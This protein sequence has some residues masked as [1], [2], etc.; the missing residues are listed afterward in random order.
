MSK[1][2]K[3]FD[4]HQIFTEF[5]QKPGSLWVLLGVA[6]IGILLLLSGNNPREESVKTPVPADT[7]QVTEMDGIIQSEKRLESELE[8]T[9]KQ[10]AG[11]GDVSVDIHLKSGS[12]RIWER[13]VRV[14]KRSQ[15]QQDQLDTEESSSDEMVLANGRDGADNPVLREELAPEVNGVLIVASGAGDARVKQILT[16]TVMTIL[17]L[18]AHRVM[19]TA[20]VG[21]EN[22]S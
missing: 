18:P 6:G 19:V 2:T 20:G 7:A 11:V 4:L 22:G 16:E 21:K 13:Q 12:R 14:T 9:L 10:I 5:R 15:Q 1:N 8:N 17:H 3:V